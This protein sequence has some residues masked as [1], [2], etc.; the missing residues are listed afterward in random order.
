MAL[1]VA[2]HVGDQRYIIAVYE[3]KGSEKNEEKFCKF[4]EELYHRWKCSIIRIEGNNGG[5]I[6]G[7]LLK[8]RNL[9]VEIITASKDKLT[10]LLEQEGRFSRGEVYF[11]PGTEAAQDQLV[12]FPN[13]EHDDMVDSIVYALG[14]GR[15]FFTGVI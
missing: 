2:A 15:E 4:V 1:T 11:L 13:A 10:R 5:G 3:F 14:G 12:T 9:A 8:K 7:S 6:I